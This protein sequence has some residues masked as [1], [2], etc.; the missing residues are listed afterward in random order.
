MGFNPANAL[1]LFLNLRFGKFFLDFRKLKLC[2]I[3]RK[4]SFGVTVF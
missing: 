1:L 2:F 4:S 3:G